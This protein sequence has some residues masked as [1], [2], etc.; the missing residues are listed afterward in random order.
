M[1]VARENVVGKAVR[2]FRGKG[3]VEVPPPMGE[4]SGLGKKTWGLQ[5]SEKI[6]QNWEGKKAF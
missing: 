5:R 1:R 3:V 2:N 6:A 4:I